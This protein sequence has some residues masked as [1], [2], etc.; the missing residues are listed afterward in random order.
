[1]DGASTSQPLVKTNAVAKRKSLWIN[2]SNFSMFIDQIGAKPSSRTVREK[3]LPWAP[4]P[5][6][7]NDP[8][9]LVV[10]EEIRHLFE[11]GN[12]WKRRKKNAGKHGTEGVEC[13][14]SSFFTKV[15][16]PHITEPVSVFICCTESMPQLVVTPCSSGASGMGM[17][18][19]LASVVDQCRK[20]TKTAIVIHSQC[21]KATF[22]ST[23]SFEPASP[24]FRM[25]LIS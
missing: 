23:R 15:F 10:G 20:Q 18:F 22:E 6:V 3:E 21:L 2:C 8:V 4:W 25:L 11:T 24:A 13:H 14:L 12:G 16:V 1:M 7:C 17:I 5:C 9:N 19:N